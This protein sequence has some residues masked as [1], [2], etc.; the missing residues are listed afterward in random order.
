MNTTNL[1]KK[2]A[3]LYCRVST[4]EQVEDGNSLVVQE[5]ACREYAEKNSYEIAEIFIEQ[6]ES[7]KTADRTELQK[8]LNY[9]SEKKNMVS[10]VII[11]KIDRLSRNTYDYGS[12]KFFFKK[13][14]GETKQ[15]KRGY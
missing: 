7:A 13:C 4:K 12:L 1:N 8:M 15:V 14:K 5:K 11:Y 2:K 6:G 3:V 9:C 10:V